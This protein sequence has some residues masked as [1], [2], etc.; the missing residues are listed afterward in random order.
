MT[1][2]F[3]LKCGHF[4]ICYQTLDLFKPAVLVDFLSCSS[5]RSG[6]GQGTTL[7]YYCQM[8]IEVRIFPWPPLTPEVGMTPFYCWLGIGVPAPHLV[9]T[10]TAMEMALLLLGDGE[11]AASPLDLP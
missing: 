5:G 7:F 11:S 9:S 3:L 8:E 4:L 10:D 2:V 1:S 6:A